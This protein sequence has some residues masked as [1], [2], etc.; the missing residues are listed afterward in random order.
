[1]SNPNNPIRFEDL[2]SEFKDTGITQPSSN[3]I[4][5]FT[6]ETFEAKPS[7]LVDLLS[8]SPLGKQQD[9]KERRECP[10]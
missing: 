9:E 8:H 1:M 10:K 2:G 4:P 5:A 6:E 7:M 3:P